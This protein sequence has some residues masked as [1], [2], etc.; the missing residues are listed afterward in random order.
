M[1]RHGK[2]KVRDIPDSLWFGENKLNNEN[3]LNF[4]R[5]DIYIYIVYQMSGVFFFVI[6]EWS[7]NMKGWKVEI[8]YLVL[9]ALSLYYLYLYWW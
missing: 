3:E 8:E 2:C 6:S 4:L 5:F 1:K 7:F 9:K